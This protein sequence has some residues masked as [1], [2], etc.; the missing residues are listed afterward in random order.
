MYYVSLQLKCKC[1]L[2]L[3]DPN[4]TIGQRDGFSEK[5]IQKLEK[6]YESSSYTTT[7]SSSYTTNESSSY[8]T[9]ESSSYPTT[10][11]SSY[12]TTESSF[13]NTTYN[14]SYTTTESSSYATRSQFITLIIITLNVF[15]LTYLLHGA[16]SFLRS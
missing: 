13:Y 11:S 3:Q 6:M 16:E 9:T 14:S 8:T 7:E 15:T 10:E 2:T 12:T 4:A 5:D 1:R